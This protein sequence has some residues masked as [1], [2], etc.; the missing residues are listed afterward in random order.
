MV[1]LVHRC[2]H[3]FCMKEDIPV[4]IKIEKIVLLYKNS[5]E[6]C[7]MDNYRGIFL[8]YI[9]LSLLQKWLYKKCSPGIDDNGSEFAFGG[10]TN[11]SVKELLLIVKLV[12]DH[13]NW[14]KIPLVLK[15]LDIRKFFDTMNF[16]TALI[17]AY[18]SGIQGKYWKIYKNVNEARRCTPLY[19][20]RRMWRNWSKSDICPRIQRCNV[21]GME[22][23]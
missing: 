15:F 22:P 23:R 1:K 16:K 20:T 13:A 12:Q 9:I 11:R 18:K 21:D 5:G 17:E 3:A 7:D 10:R 19:T 8:R 4:Q 2:L 6:L 14:T